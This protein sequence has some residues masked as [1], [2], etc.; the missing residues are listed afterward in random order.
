MKYCSSL[1]MNFSERVGAQIILSITRCDIRCCFTHDAIYFTLK[2][3]CNS[4]TACADVNRWL[5]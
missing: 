5:K 4:V 2:N 1:N 3:G